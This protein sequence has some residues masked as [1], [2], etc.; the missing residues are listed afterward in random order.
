MRC[1]SRA[2]HPG[3]GPLSLPRE[4]A[5]APY[6]PGEI[7][8]YLRLADAQPTA[9][10]RARANALVCLSAGA[11]LVGGELRHVRGHDVVLRSGGLV[12]EVSGR[13]CRAVP[14]LWQYHARL[15]AAAELLGEAYLVSGRNPDSHNVTNPLVSS[16]SGGEDLGRLDLFRMRSSWLTCVA[17]AI[18]LRAFMDAAGISCSQRLGDLVAG[19]APLWRRTP[20]LW[21]RGPAT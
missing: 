19:L 2:V 18:G 16:L 4:R 9:L 7:A 10:R 21:C 11:G 13:R 8:S 14:V 17:E 6:R 5:K 1:L 3:P 12:V 15:L 20:S